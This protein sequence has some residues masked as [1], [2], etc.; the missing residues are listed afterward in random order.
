MKALALSNGDLV[1]SQRGH[2]TISG[3]A[4]IRQDLALALSE[5]LGDD[6]FHTDWGSVLPSY[7]GLPITSRTQSLVQAEVSRVLAYYITVRDEYI[8]QDRL[9]RSRSRF[10]SSDIV[11]TIDSIGV[12]ISPNNADNIQVKISLTTLAGNTIT[13]NRTVTS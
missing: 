5:P 9:N 4:K 13:I 11:S 2:A 1:V 10:D 3:S 7:I 6:R 8:I 12:S